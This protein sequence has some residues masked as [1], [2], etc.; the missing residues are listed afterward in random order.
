[1]AGQW[2]A[3]ECGARRDRRQTP[4]FTLIELLVVVAIIA[5]LISILLPSL[6]NARDQAK[7]VVCGS[8]LKQLGNA[9]QIYFAENRDRFFPYE[10]HSLGY[11]WLRPSLSNVDEVMI[12]PSTTKM[13]DSQKNALS[14]HG[15]AMTSRNAWCWAEAGAPAP[16][17]TS[18][19]DPE[20]YADGSYAY[21]GWLFDPSNTWHGIAY[22]W[23]A[24]AAMTSL[25]H[26][27]HWKRLSAIRYTAKT[28]VMLDAFEMLIYP[29]NETLAND[30]KFSWPSTVL[31]E[32]LRTP[33]SIHLSDGGRSV[34][35][36]WKEQL[37]RGMP[38]RHSKF[39]TNLVAIDGHVER[40]RPQALLDMYWGPKFEPGDHNRRPIVWP[41]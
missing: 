12:C 33:R 8:Q 16:P 2:L 17:Q 1:M 9:Y 41:F 36:P 25:D 27:Y 19:P 20:L 6:R 10:S 15:R 32:D 24:T 3:A 21:N 35:T 23:Q 38:D 14:W 18:P 22:T 34:F 26:P 28:P 29:V 11:R 5:L 7:A 13:N 39:T 37:I 30:M 4:G 31:L 40:A